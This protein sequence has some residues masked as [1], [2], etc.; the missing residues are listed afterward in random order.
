MS[1]RFMISMSQSGKCARALWAMRTKVVGEDKP[2][3]LDDAAEE[4]N[5]HEP[6]IKNKLRKLGW[7]IIEGGECKKCQNG[8]KGIHVDFTYKDVFFVGHMDG[9]ARRDGKTYVLEVKSMSQFEFDRWMRGK[10]EE[11]PDYAAQLTCYMKAENNYNALYAVKN[12]NTGYLFTM[13]Q[14]GAPA[15]YL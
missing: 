8:R 14:E 10:W 15:K 1:D 5:L 7:E 6:I 9:I 2:S 12:R 11:F 13:I 3:W 4:G